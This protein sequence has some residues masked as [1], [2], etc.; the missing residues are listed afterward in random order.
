M[1]GPGVRRTC[2]THG[3]IALVSP[4]RPRA[5]KLPVVA[6]ARGSRGQAPRST[7]SKFDPSVDGINGDAWRLLYP[8]VGSGYAMIVPDLA[9]YVSLNVPSS[10]TWKV[11]ADVLEDGTI[12]LSLGL[13]CQPPQ[14]ASPPPVEADIVVKPER[15]AVVATHWPA[16]PQHALKLLV[17]PHLIRSEEDLRRVLESKM[18]GHASRSETQP[19]PEP[20]ATNEPPLCPSNLSSKIKRLSPTEVDVDRSVIDDIFAFDHIRPNRVRTIPELANGKLAGIRLFGIGPSSVLAALGLENG[21]RIESID[22]HSLASPDE[23]MAIYEN[24]KTATRVDVI[25]NRNGKAMSLHYNIK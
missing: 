25:V 13:S 4:T 1:I 24:V 20:S 17:Q 22:G 15:V 3:R 21:D 23:A 5:S 7:L 6:G 10:P 14:S 9:G 19:K 8:L 11:K 2:S 16:R 12:H 18:S